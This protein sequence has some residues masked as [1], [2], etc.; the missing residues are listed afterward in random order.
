MI[1]N[2]IPLYCN[3]PLLYCILEI[4]LTITF[5]CSM[6]A[7][8]K[9][10]NLL[11]QEDWE[12]KPTGR[13]IKW[14]LTVGRYIVVTTELIVII[15]FISRFKLDR[16]LSDLY[17][18]IEIKQARIRSSQQ[19]EKE[20]RLTQKNLKVIKELTGMINDPSMALTN[21]ARLVP[22]NVTLDNLEINKDKLAI[23]GM[24]LSES[25]I[26][27]LINNLK[28]SPYFTEIKIENIS[29]E[30]E[31]EISFS[32]EVMLNSNLNVQTRK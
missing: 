5:Y 28:Q 9:E 6:A 19:F 31:M 18:E 17:E 27:T 11:P 12:K 20:F 3:Q 16:D 24:S 30:P 21:F 14:A 29:K 15:A 22:L 26:A 23:E 7:L 25:G 2:I 8:K 13:L 32:L 10:I 4:S 1:Q